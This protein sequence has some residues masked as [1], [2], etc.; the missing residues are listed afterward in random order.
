MKSPRDEEMAQRHARVAGG[1]GQ[2]SVRHTREEGSHPELECRL[3]L[4]FGPP[5]RTLFAFFF[6]LGSRAG[7]LCLVIKKSTHKLTDSPPS[8]GD[9]LSSSLTCGLGSV[10]RCKLGGCAPHTRSPL[11]LVC[12]AAGAVG[13]SSDT[14]HQSPAA[15]SSA[16]GGKPGLAPPAVH[17]M[18]AGTFP[19]V[20]LTH[21]HPT[22]TSRV[23]CLP[24]P[25]IHLLS[26]SC[27]GGRRG[28][29]AVACPWLC[30]FLQEGSPALPHDEVTSN[31]LQSWFTAVLQQWPWK[32]ATPATRPFWAPSRVRC[33]SDL[34]AQD[35]R[36][37]SWGIFPLGSF[38]FIIDL[39]GNHC[40]F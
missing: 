34:H 13:A 36:L 27:E 19:P 1:P 39:W 38:V 37:P 7:H 22:V 30:V 4:E 24:R 2:P 18:V 15:P 17:P 21:P 8:E 11:L 20:A 40:T 35:F 33:G 10:G 32:P 26:A 12:V 31:A 3:R 28:R 6:L 16:G 25:H 9:A 29:R 14:R 23:M 5:P